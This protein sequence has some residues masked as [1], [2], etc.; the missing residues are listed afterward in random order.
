MHVCPTPSSLFMQSLENFMARDSP[1][2]K[3]EEE[4]EESDEAMEARRLGGRF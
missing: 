1:A 2:E 3:E 4:E